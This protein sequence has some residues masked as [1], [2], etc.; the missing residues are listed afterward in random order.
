MRNVI[1]AA[2]TS[3]LIT[4]VQ[5]TDVNIRNGQKVYVIFSEKRTRIIQAN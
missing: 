1:S 5:G 4:V 2:F 3:G